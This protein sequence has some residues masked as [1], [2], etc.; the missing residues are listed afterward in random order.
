M[1]WNIEWF[2]G[3]NPEPSAAEKSEQ[4]KGAK[5]VLLQHVPDILL[6]QEITD[7]KAF[8]RLVSAV[9]GMNVHVFSKFLNFDG[10]TPAPQQCVIASTL[11]LHSGWFEAFKPTKAL[12]NMPRGFAFAAVKHPDGR[13]IML[14]SVHLRS[15]RGDEVPKIARQIAAT[16]AESVKQLIAHQKV[17]REKFKNER[18]IGWVIGGDFN[19]NHD[20]QFPLCTAIRDLTA[21]GFHNSW[22]NTPRKN[23]LTWR[24]HPHFRNYESTTF[25]YILTKGFKKTE[26]RLIPN[27]PRRVSDHA[28]VMLKLISE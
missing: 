2:P 3:G 9:E 23:R 17:M 18:I 7:E 21:A 8:E 19:T 14:Y 16:R 28:P 22:G 20:K 26:A 24:N 27:V 5:K 25:D 12:P 15:N 1:I 6:A 4:M 11:E 10:V 13:L